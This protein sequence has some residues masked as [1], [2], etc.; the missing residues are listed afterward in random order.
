MFKTQSTKDRESDCK[1]VPW[2]KAGHFPL[3]LYFCTSLAFLHL[4]GLKQNLCLLIRPRTIFFL[5]SQL[6]LHLLHFDHGLKTR[7]D[8]LGQAWNEYW[9][10][11]EPKLTTKFYQLSVFFWTFFGINFI[12]IFFWYF[13]S[14]APKLRPNFDFS[15]SP[16]VSRRLVTGAFAR[17]QSWPVRPLTH[18]TVNWNKKRMF[19][20]K[21]LYNKTEES[22]SL[23][24]PYDSNVPN[25]S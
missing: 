12:R 20:A 9:E 8:S 7:L 13:A 17:A 18:F 24:G 1:K 14:F 25:A 23:Q 19:L 4:L 11:I 16:F 5:P 10:K 22:F 3:H 2:F 6:K 15:C 21:N